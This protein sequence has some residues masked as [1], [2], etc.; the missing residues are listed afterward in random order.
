MQFSLSHSSFHVK[1]KLVIEQ[2]WVIEP[3]SIANYYTNYCTIFQESIRS[4][5]IHDIVDKYLSQP[6]PETYLD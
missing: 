5:T 6:I 3:I 4:C 2:S 1:Q